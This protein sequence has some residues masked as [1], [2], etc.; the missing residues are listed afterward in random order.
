M[1]AKFIEDNFR[2]QAIGTYYNPAVNGCLAT[3]KLWHCYNNLNRRSKDPSE[4][5]RAKKKRTA[6]QDLDFGDIDV[7]SMLYCFLSCLFHRF[8]AESCYLLNFI[9]LFVVRVFVFFK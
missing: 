3:G 8:M 1:A 6:Q 2:N 7:Q 4:S 9:E 5:S